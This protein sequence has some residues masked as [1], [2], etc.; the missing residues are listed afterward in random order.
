MKTTFY[1]IEVLKSAGCD[2]WW[3]DS[4]LGHPSGHY[5][6]LVFAQEDAKRYRNL[7]VVCRIIKVTREVVEDHEGKVVSSN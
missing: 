1:Q 7:G 3:E 4:E 5:P 2:A 6:A